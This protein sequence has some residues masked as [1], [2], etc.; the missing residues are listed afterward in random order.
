MLKKGQLTLFIIIGAL[1]VFTVVIL[2]FTTS[3]V[4][5][6]NLDYEIEKILP[7][8]SLG[9][10]GQVNMYL[11]KCMASALEKGIFEYG[12]DEGLL[13]S[14]VSGDVR[15]CMGLGID[16]MKEQGIR[17]K[18]RGDFHLKVSVSSESITV[19][20]KQPMDIIFDESSGRIDKFQYTLPLSS[21]YELKLDNS[22]TVTEKQTFYSPDQNAEIIFDKGVIAKGPDGK[23]LSKFSIKMYK[24]KSPISVFKVYYDFTPDGA[25]FSPGFDVKLKYNQKDFERVRSEYLRKGFDL[26]E[27]N[28]RVAFDDIGSGVFRPYHNSPQSVD[29]VKNIVYAKPNHFTHLYTITGCEDVV[30]YISTRVLALD[31]S[32][33]TCE[34]KSASGEVTWEVKGNLESCISDNDSFEAYFIVSEGDEFKI[35]DIDGKRLGKDSKLGKGLGLNIP[36]GAV[37]ADGKFGGGLTDGAG[38]GIRVTSQGNHK[39]NSVVTDSDFAKEDD[40]TCAFLDIVIKMK[41]IGVESN[42]SVS[43]ADANATLKGGNAFSL[44][45]SYVENPYWGNPLGYAGFTVNCSAAGLIDRRTLA[46]RWARDY[47]GSLTMCGGKHFWRAMEDAGAHYPDFGGACVEPDADWRLRDWIR[48][49]NENTYLFEGYDARGCNCVNPMFSC[50]ELLECQQ[51]YTEDCKVKREGTEDNPDKFLSMRCEGHDG[52]T[53][54][55]P[56]PWNTEEKC[57]PDQCALCTKGEVIPCYLQEGVCAGSEGICVEGVY[58]ITNFCNDSGVYEKIEGYEE[59]ELTCSDGLDNDCDGKVDFYDKDCYLKKKLPDFYLGKDV[60]YVGDALVLEPDTNHIV[61]GVIYLYRFR[62]INDNSIVQD[63]SESNS[64]TIKASDAR[65]SI[66]IDVKFKGGTEL[67]DEKS[68]NITVTNRAPGPITGFLGIPNSSK[69]GETLV[70]DI[71]EDLDPDGD[72]LKVYYRF[73]NSYNVFKDQNWSLSN[74]YN[75][76]L[77]NVPYFVTISAKATDG[78]EMTDVYS[79]TIEVQP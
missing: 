32:I 57:L 77:A 21:D 72:D 44:F 31:S 24:S 53:Y 51:C 61:E 50:P 64:Y 17:I 33:D 34:G 52:G 4:N 68:Y 76:P 13:N 60:Y 5:K 16:V 45:G 70:L 79:E 56:S 6:K 14:F 71:D 2:T 46:A 9:G 55:F 22:C 25:Y 54:K 12:L 10:K 73:N 29:T 48:C 59:E 35:L 19:D 78:L 74:T 67:S 36:T 62:N 28:I 20:L 49:C 27:E 66:S 18:K 26:K 39:F 8:S 63:W 40:G 3:D 43:E 65:D 42:Y 11:D 38:L 58:H 15:A 69:S 30:T 47:P 7:D 23:C 75:L 41:G 1:L 37:V